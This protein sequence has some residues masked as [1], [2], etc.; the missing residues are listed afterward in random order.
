MQVNNKW[1]YPSVHV[2]YF[3]HS[4]YCK[5]SFVHGVLISR[6]P[7]R[8]LLLGVLYSRETR[9]IPDFMCKMHVRDEFMA[10][11]IREMIAL[12]NIAKIRCSRIRQFTVYRLSNIS[13]GNLEFGLLLLQLLTCISKTRFVWF[14]IFVVY[15]TVDGILV[16]V[17]RCAGGLKKV[18]LSMGLPCHGHFVL[19]K[20]SAQPRHSHIYIY[21]LI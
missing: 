12:A 20:C 9:F 1:T 13:H 16:T 18:W 14:C 10:F 15:V 6:F 3:D 4:S 2:S 19:G 17:H 7:Y 5:P 21:I 11:Y 8:V